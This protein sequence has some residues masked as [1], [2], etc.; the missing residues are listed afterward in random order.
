VDDELALF[1]VHKSIEQLLAKS[2]VMV[3]LHV[4][5]PRARVFL[6][7]SSSD[8]KINGWFL[9][10]GATHHMTGRWE[11]FSDLNTNVH[12]SVKFNDSRA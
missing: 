5:K 11:F 10:S 6:S 12:S 3:L 2:V 4:D 7:D 9:D 8:G 1:L